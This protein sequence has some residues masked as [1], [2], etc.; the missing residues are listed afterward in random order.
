MAYSPTMHW[1]LRVLCVRPESRAMR[2]GTVGVA[3]ADGLAWQARKPRAQ[4][5][6]LHERAGWTPPPR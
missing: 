5:N 6:M 4:G 2:Q 1:T 3:R